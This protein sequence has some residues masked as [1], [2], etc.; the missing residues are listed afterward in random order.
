MFSIDG[1]K[2]ELNEGE[3][4]VMPDGQPQ[5]VYGKERLKMLLAAVY[6]SVFE[7]EFIGMR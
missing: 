6:E 4:I 2:Y 3:S 5:A 1:I 7:E